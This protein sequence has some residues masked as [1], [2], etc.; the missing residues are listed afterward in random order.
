MLAITSSGNVRRPAGIPERSDRNGQLRF[1]LFTAAIWPCQD[2]DIGF[3]LTARM[4]DRAVLIE[5]T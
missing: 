2:D 3:L 1:P 4:A 5:V